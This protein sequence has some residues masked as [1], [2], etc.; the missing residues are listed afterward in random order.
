MA[1][2]R[3]ES[4][5]SEHNNNAL[6]SNTAAYPASILPSAIQ[7][8]APRH[9]K[10][11]RKSA[12]SGEPPSI[13]TGLNQAI[14]Q[15]QQ[16]SESQALKQVPRQKFSEFVPRT[17]SMDTS[18]NKSKKPEYRK[19]SSKTVA[20]IEK[21]GIEIAEEMKH[22]EG[23]MPEVKLLADKKSEEKEKNSEENK[24]KN[25]ES[26]SPL[27]KLSSSAGKAIMRYKPSRIIQFNIDL[28]ITNLRN[29]CIPCIPQHYLQHPSNL[30]LMIFLY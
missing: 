2:L 4:T 22:D 25:D 17:I 24:K 28:L 27:I 14:P 10:L 21:K 20:A 9:S 3:R 5:R 30:N 6:G 19:M 7:N 1:K 12:I 8:I 15:E 11:E 16:E 29:C 23:V 26:F 13:I 18:Q